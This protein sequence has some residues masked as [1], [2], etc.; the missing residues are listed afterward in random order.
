MQRQ[1]QPEP[2]YV[3][4][5]DPRE[6]QRL[7][8]Q[9]ASIEQP[10]RLLMQAAGLEA[11]WRVLDLGT[12]LG[13]VARIVAELI[14]PTGWV[15][16]ID[17]SLAA[18]AA[19]RE[20][21]IAGAGAR[22]TFAE[23]NVTA[24]QASEHFHA[25]VARCLLFH[26]SDPA[27]VVRHHVAN[28]LQAGG[29]F[30]ALD[31]DVGS[32]RTEPPVAIVDTAVAWAHRGF[33]AAGAWPTIGARL[34][35]I[36]DKA[37]LTRVSTFGIQAYV[38]PRDPSGPALLAGVVRSL[39]PALVTHGIATAEE[40]DLNTLEQRIAEATDE[41]D[42]VVLLPTVVGAWGRSPVAS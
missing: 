13:H 5:D 19:A 22:I 26:M 41:V 6:L 17:Q 14:G 12:G 9:A 23:G 16:G 37:G 29:L 33:R 35:R 24:W 18:I 20:R 1:S 40:L 21:T 28:N 31:F 7:E 3:L 10:T 11:G 32:V 42:A 34:A 27:A 2:S 15:V 25:I 36:L 4:G 8:R 39:A 38:Q 30:V